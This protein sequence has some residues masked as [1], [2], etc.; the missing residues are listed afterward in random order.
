MPE[1]VSTA[2]G[3]AEVPEQTFRLQ[4]HRPETCDLIEYFW[5]LLTRASVYS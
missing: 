3:L 4:R 2:S 1:C 5:R